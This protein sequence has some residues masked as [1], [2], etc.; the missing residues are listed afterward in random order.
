M[1]KWSIPIALAAACSGGSEVLGL[2]GVISTGL[3]LRLGILKFYQSSP[4]TSHRIPK[5]VDELLIWLHSSLR[6]GGVKIGVKTCY[7]S[8]YSTGSDTTEDARNTA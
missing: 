4:G 1:K 6:R 7:F 3:G 2:S 8:P 5:L